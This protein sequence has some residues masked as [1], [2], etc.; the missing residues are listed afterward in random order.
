[1]GWEEPGRRVLLPIWFAVQNFLFLFY[2]L[3]V[4]GCF[5]VACRLYL[6]VVVVVFLVVGSRLPNTD[7]ILSGLG[8]H[9]GRLLLVSNC[10]V[11]VAFCLCR[12][13]RFFIPVPS[14]AHTS[15]YKGESSAGQP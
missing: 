12:G 5:C 10:R 8:S 3:S 14:S 4:V 6:S 9:C 1:M 7:S 11:S 13:C 2:P 15:Y